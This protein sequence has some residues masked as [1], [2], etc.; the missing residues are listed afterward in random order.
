MVTNLYETDAKNY[1]DIVEEGVF[2]PPAIELTN[3]IEDSIYGSKLGL[4]IGTGTGVLISEAQR[5]F[6]KDIVMFGLD[7]S[8]EMLRIACQK[9]VNYLVTG[10]L[11]SIPF[12]DDTF[13][14]VSANF[15]LSHINNT[16]ELKNNVQRVLKREGHFI[17]NAWGKGQSEYNEIWNSVLYE[18]ISKMHI[19]KLCKRFIPHEDKFRNSDE[20][21]TELEKDNQFILSKSYTKKFSNQQSLETYLACRYSFLIGKYLKEI[22]STRQWNEFT[23]KMYHRFLVE[24]GETIETERAVNFFAFTCKK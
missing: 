23:A 2:L 6:G 21:I 12:L 20:A 8:P 16:A 17:F 7:S 9:K 10:V 4:D 24:F 3:I 22:L 15:V 1:A 14:F 19:E 13:D 11:P 18:F 5:R